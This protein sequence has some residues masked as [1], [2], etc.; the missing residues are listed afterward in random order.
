MIDAVTGTPLQFKK[1][2]NKYVVRVEPHKAILEPDYFIK[3]I[4]AAEHKRSEE[5]ERIESGGLDSDEE[6]AQKSAAQFQEWEKLQKANNE[7]YLMRTILPVLYQGMKVVDLERPEA[8]LE[9]LALYLLKHQDQIKLPQK[10]QKQH[11]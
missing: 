1:F 10:P 8:P 3:N 6:L 4:E 11:H 7:E 9:Y 5:I 2:I